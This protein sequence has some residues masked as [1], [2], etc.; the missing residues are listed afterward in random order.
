M[1][2]FLTLTAWVLCSSIYAQKIVLVEGSLAPLKGQKSVK[3]V[4]TYEP[5]AVGKYDN[6]KEYIEAR[7]K[8]M[9]SGKGDEWEK[10]W[11]A[12][13]KE[14]FEPR[15]KELFVK[16]SGIST[17]DDAARYTLEIKTTKTEP[18]W[19][20]GVMRSPAFID[21]DVWIV[22]T[23]NPQK[24][25]AKIR[26]TKAPGRDAMGYDFETGVRLE[27]AYAKM[28]KSLGGFIKSKAK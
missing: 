21:A 4:F 11:Y 19:N 14:R 17:T 23:A 26:V 27:E 10:K 16:H 1:K 28:G 12:D 7:K 5:M 18:G 2:L 22:E 24:V 3:T 15:F 25:I 9:K 20:V 6:E 13:R 8:D